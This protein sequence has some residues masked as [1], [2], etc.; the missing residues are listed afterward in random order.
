MFLCCVENETRKSVSTAEIIRLTHTHTHTL[1]NEPKRY[2]T[3][4]NF[5]TM[6]HSLIRVSD[7]WE[8]EKP[9]KRFCHVNTPH[10]SKSLPPFTQIEL[11][12]TVDSVCK[13]GA[14]NCNIVWPNVK[15]DWGWFQSKIK[16]FDVSI[17][18]EYEGFDELFSIDNQD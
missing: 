11:V 1:V 7:K 17:R 14:L 9:A 6:A 15:V 18:M 4:N 16:E 2:F 5:R 10:G 13:M 12:I 3:I 8:R